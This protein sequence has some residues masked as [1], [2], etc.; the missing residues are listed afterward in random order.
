[1]I[2]E[3]NVPYLD[4]EGAAAL[5]NV[6]T[7][8][9]R[10]WMRTK[11]PPP[12]AKQFEQPTFPLEELG[13][14]TRREQIYKMSRGGAY[15]YMPDMS[16]FGVTALPPSIDGAGETQIVTKAGAE[17]AVKVAQAEKLNIEIAQM[18]SELVS[19]RAVE[20]SLSEA[21][22][23]V[24]TRLMNIPVKLAP[25][26]VNIDDVQDARALLESHVHEVLTELVT[27]WDDRV[28]VEEE[29]DDLPG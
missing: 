14:W 17:T 24:K 27:S 6:T 12:T 9:M 16:R 25:L 29:D 4:L 8:T 19:A 10:N 2:I 20:Q 22:S 28:Q 7:Q 23:L 15:P 18:R 26:V 5:C 13:E 1:M 21:N 11:N 3:D